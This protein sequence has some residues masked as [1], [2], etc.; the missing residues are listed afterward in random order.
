MS[1]FSEKVVLLKMIIMRIVWVIFYECFVENRTRIVDIFVFEKESGGGMISYFK[2]EEGVKEVIL[3]V[4]NLI[5]ELED[6]KK[7]VLGCYE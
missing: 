3:N 1:H 5:N 4:D 6:A 7:F 2:N